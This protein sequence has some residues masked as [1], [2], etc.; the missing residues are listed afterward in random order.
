MFIFSISYA[1]NETVQ[2][3]DFS[4]L[5]VSTSI[6]MELIQSNENK[7]EIEI[8]RGERSELKIEEKNNSLKVYIKGKNS[9]GGS[10]TKANIKLYFKQL[11]DISVAA[12][13]RVTT[14]DVIKSDDFDADVSS[15][16]RLSISLEANSLDSDISSS[17]TLKING[18]VNSVDVSATSSGSF[19]GA[20]LKTKIADLDASSSGSIKIWVTES[21]EASTS[22]SGKIKYKGSPTKKDIDKSISGGSIKAVSM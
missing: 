21:I 6:K 7:M 12:S 14:D 19:Q 18:E 9:W 2:L 11:D 17:G 5:S 22:S 1:Q 13:A 3:D 8:T 16:G 4:K 20:D 10:K 15:S